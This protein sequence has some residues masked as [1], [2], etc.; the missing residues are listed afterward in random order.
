[1]S[2]SAERQIENLLYRYCELIDAGDFEGLAQLFG[3]ALH[4]S[5]S[6]HAVSG[7][8]EILDYYT[9]RTRRFPDTGTPK[10][11]HLTTN[12]IIEVDE[13]AG[14]ATSRSYFTVL[15][16]VAGTLALQPIVAGRYEDRL[17]RYDSEWRFTERRKFID[18]AGD[19]SEHLI[20][21]P[22]ERR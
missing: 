11:K 6:G 8:K 16:A 18:L 22:A 17:E 21:V 20:G 12:V 5:S 2:E 1:M 10:T 14:Q 4:T 7:P 9:N 15:Q 13:V 19:L 3:H